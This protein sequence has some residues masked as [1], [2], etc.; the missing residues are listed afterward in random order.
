MSLD[1]NNNNNNTSMDLDSADRPFDNIINFRDVGK[2]INTL[3]G[4]ECVLNM[5]TYKEKT[6]YITR[7]LREGVLFRSARVCLYSLKKKKKVTKIDKKLTKKSSTMPLN[8][9]NAGY[10]MNSAFRRLLTCDLCTLPLSP[11]LQISNIQSTY[12]ILTMKQHR[13]QNGHAK[14]PSRTRPRLRSTT[15]RTPPRR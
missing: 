15:G 8:E 13:T 12:S 11:F 1:H 2:S 7:I 4:R 5:Y 3:M 10:S 14:T 9:I 6:D